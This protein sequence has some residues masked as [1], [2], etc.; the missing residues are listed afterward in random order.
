M[1]LKHIN[2]QLRRYEKLAQDFEKNGEEIPT[3]I[4]TQ[5]NHWNQQHELV[6]R[7]HPDEAGLGAPYIPESRGPRLNVE[8]P[9]SM[10]EETHDI[11]EKIDEEVG[12][13]DEYVRRKLHF[14]S[15]KEMYS[16]P[17]TLRGFSA[18][19]IDALAMSIYNI[20]TKNQFMIISDQTG[21]GKGRVA[22]GIL[23]YAHFMGKKPLFLTIR[24]NL[25]SDMYRDLEDIYM[26]DM[27]PEKEVPKSLT[28][29]KR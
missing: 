7:Q 27:N 15:V 17:L 25:F 11:L 24:A 12:G 29:T 1:T 14:K 3:E 23:R 8:V 13:V 10:D 26:D 4:Y 20:E 5:L 6:S 16:D 28:N 2:R 18:E 21:I 19:Q 9:D 22:A